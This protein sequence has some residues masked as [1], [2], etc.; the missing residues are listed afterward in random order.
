[1]PK[2]TSNLSVDEQQATVAA[3]TVAERKVAVATTHRE[4]E[5]LVIVVATTR[6][7]LDETRARERTTALTW[8]KENTIARHLK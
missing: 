1:M 6:K 4:Q 2:S 3:A 8:E 5:A 7:T